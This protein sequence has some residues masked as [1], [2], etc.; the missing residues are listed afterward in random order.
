MS[1]IREAVERLSADMQEFLHTQPW[2]AYRPHG[3]G[4]DIEDPT[5]LLKVSAP[6]ARLLDEALT[7][8]VRQN[9]LLGQPASIEQIAEFG[10]IADALAALNRGPQEDQPHA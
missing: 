5:L 6:D 9:E 4:G 10:R 7:L 1:R 3:V 8:L 2:P